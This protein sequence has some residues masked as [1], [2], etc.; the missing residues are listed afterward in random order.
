M[1]LPKSPSSPAFVQ[2]YQWA[3]RPTK[4]L[5]SCKEYGDIFVS[6]WPGYGLTVFVNDPK[7]IEQIFTAPQTTFS[8]AEIYEIL[9]P[10]LGDQSLMLMDGKPHRRQRSLMMPPLHGERMR[11][12]GNFICELT[13]EMMEEW[14][15]GE[16]INL[17]AYLQD[18]SLK[19]MFRV[20]FGSD[21]RELSIELRQKIKEMLE[22]SSSALTALHFFVK[23]LQKDLGPWSPWGRFIRLR[24]EVDRLLYAEIAQR[25]QQPQADGADL[26]SLLMSARDEEGQPMSD[27]E[28][29]DEAMTVLTGK[30][31][32]FSAI[33]CSLYS[34]YKHPE[35]CQRLQEE[36]DN[37]SD[38]S[39][40]NAI[41]K[42]PYLTATT[43]ET[44]RLYPPVVVAMRVVRTPFEIM[45]YEF[46]VGSQIVAD[47]YSVHH[48]E[49][50]F[51]NPK[52][53]NPERFLSRQ[54]SSYEYLPFGGGN[55]RCI[56]D[57]FAPFQVKLMLATI[58]SRYQ[59]E[60]TDNLPINPVRRGAG[61]APDKDIY[62]RVTGYHHQTENYT[63]IPTPLNVG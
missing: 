47:I 21:E 22:C 42:L 11:S 28:L 4:F 57:V 59:L 17:S 3:N 16:V 34:V 1:K 27:Q 15:L 61:V 62:M 55:R 53:F 63:S 36:L 5:D 31:S 51:P 46:P 38:P 37:I 25:H 41:V 7:A 50:L 26:L 14:K 49:D 48:R 23:P 40:T 60:L 18:L 6:Q 32:I 13:E 20:I 43:Q 35:V 45:G 8:T 29:R 24:N 39:N 2:I 56:G 44:M 33:I 19:I 30:D 12:Y 58:V 9:R 54:F 10:I 52:Q